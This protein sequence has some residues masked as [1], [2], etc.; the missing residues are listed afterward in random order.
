MI[1]TIVITGGPCGGK[2]TALKFLRN[3]LSKKGWSLVLVP[4]CATTL[5]S[6]GIAPWT[7]TRLEFQTAVFELQLA[8]ETVFFSAAHKVRG[9]NV[10]VVC[11]RGLMDGKGYLSDEEFEGVL[12]EH[13]ITESEAFA[14]YEAVFHL[15]SAAK[16]DQGAYTLE[17]NE[18][19]KEDTEEATRL[20]NR[21][22]E[23]WANHPRRRIIGNEVLFEQ[24]VVHLL[25]E[26]QDFLDA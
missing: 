18:T 20:D 1:R 25:Q 26:V 2:T 10:L 22:L 5:I 11:D 24:K 17:N 23:A 12:T 13:G 6:G 8:E 3:E 19:R 7:S 14:R 4:E 15:E 9:T 16:G 21:I